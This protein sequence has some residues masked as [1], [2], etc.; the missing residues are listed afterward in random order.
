M[1]SLRASTTKSEWLPD[2]PTASVPTRRWK[3]PSITTWDDSRNQ[4]HPTDSAEEV[5]WEQ[6][7][8]GGKVLQ[9]ASLEKMTKPFKSNYAFGL[10]VETVG[11]HKVIQH[12]G[13]IEG[14]NTE[15]EY[16]PE[17]K[18]TVVVLGNV[19]GM[20]PTEIAKKL[21]A[22]AHG[23]AV[24]LPSERK[25]ITLDSKVLSRYVGAYQLNPGANMLITL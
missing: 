1:A 10:A 8:F 3:L 18:L 20:A 16:Y 5:K 6:G 17:D 22:L 12:G 11:A 7:L 2:D 14:F 24:K 23:D 13:G 25:E 15:L 4:N 9:A 19:N 21:A